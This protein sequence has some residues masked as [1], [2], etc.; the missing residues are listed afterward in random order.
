MVIVK[1]TPSIVYW[2]GN[3]LCL[4]ITNRCS[5]DCYYCFRRYKN[6]IGDFNLKLLREPSQK[7]IIKQLKEVIN[8]KHWNEIVFCGFGEPTA[9]LDCLLE[10]TRWIKK[11]FGIAVR[12]DTNGH[13]HLLNPRRDVIKELKD[14]GVDK[15]S[16][17]LNAHDE[18]TYIEV[19]KPQFEKAFENVLKFIEKAGREFDTEITTITIPEVDIQKVRKIAEKMGVK[20]RIR[21]YIPCFW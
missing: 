14:A 10:I 6:G 8:R 20:F 7:E 2:L 12:I 18:A 1:K 3:K 21:Q 16:V 9:R 5:N 13:G 4:N 19:C 11:H 17:S 15:I